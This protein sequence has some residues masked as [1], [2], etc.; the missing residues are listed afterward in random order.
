MMSVIQVGKYGNRVRDSLVFPSRDPVHSKR[1]YLAGICKSLK[2]QIKFPLRRESF[3]AFTRPLKCLSFIIIFHYNF[4]FYQYISWR[5]RKIN[6]FGM[7]GG[8]F[9]L[10]RLR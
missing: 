6:D 8:A 2:G 1:K 10:T 4:Y 7:N 5:E 3:I 9:N